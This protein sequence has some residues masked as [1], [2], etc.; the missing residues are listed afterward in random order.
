VHEAELRVGISGEG[1]QRSILQSHRGQPVAHL[2][3]PD[4]I[5]S[6]AGFGSTPG[7]GEVGLKG[8]QPDAAGVAAGQ[9]ADVGRDAS[10]EVA[11]V[12]LFDLTASAA[13]AREAADASRRV[14]ALGCSVMKMPKPIRFKDDQGGNIV[15]LDRYR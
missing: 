9:Q 12:R 10:A 1:E 15:P 8:I 13:A 4:C 5:Q 2:L 14:R 7:I 6:I 3:T 11:V